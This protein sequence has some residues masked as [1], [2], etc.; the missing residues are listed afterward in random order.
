GYKQNAYGTG[1][2]AG[3]E[4][5]Q[6]GTCSG[7]LNAFSFSADYRI[8]PRFDTYA[9]FLYTGVKNGLANGYLN[10]NN[11]NPTAGVRYRF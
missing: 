11:I 3:C 4:T 2:N 5:I 10:T 9:G 7:N 1:A 8:S 6:S